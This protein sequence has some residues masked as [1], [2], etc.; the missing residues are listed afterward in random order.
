[1]K[2]EEGTLIRFIKEGEKSNKGVKRTSGLLNLARDWELKVDTHV[3]L[4]I[5]EDIVKTKYR[6]DIILFSRGSKS[7][8]FIELIVPW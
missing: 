3:K 8:I 7:I 4:V 2:N 1:M 6:P 5:P